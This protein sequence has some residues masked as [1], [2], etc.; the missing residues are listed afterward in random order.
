M[1]TR[2]AQ[3]FWT[4]TGGNALFLR[5]MLKDQVAAGRI[6]QV[7]GVWMW[8]EDVAVSQNISDIVGRQL[9]RLTPELALVVDTLSQ[10]EPLDVDV[11]CD[12][13]RPRAIWNPPSRCTWSPSSGGRHVVGTA[14]ASAVR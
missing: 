10:C 4:L 8:D 5:Q 13:V 14:G 9:G 11:L 2:S 12:L 7:A 3:R 1:D 6:R